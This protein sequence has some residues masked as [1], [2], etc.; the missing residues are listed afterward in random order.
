MLDGLSDSPADALVALSALEQK[1]FQKAVRAFETGQWD[2]VL[3]ACAV[4]LAAHPECLPVRRLE[5]AALLRKFP[6]RSGFIPKLSAT[7]TRLVLSFGGTRAKKSDFE[8]LAHAETALRKNP[9]DT[10]ALRLLGEAATSASASAATSALNWA[11]TAVFAYEAI[12]EMEPDNRPNLL[13]LGDALLTAQRPADALKIA[14]TLL[15]ENPVDGDAQ[16]LM[17]KASIAQTVDK[18]NWDGAGD[19]YAKLM[20]E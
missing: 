9:Y 20:A 18:G 11:E 2:Y 19:F 17:R 8:Q 1:R 4:L 10:V 14:D 3:A 6:K 15:A 7:V 13:A 12:R 5:R 16:T